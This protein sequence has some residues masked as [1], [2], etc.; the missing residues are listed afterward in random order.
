MTFIYEHTRKGSP[1][2]IPG[3][4]K[5]GKHLRFR[6]EDIERWI[7]DHEKAANGYVDGNGKA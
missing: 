7:Q 4:Y 2:P 5:F 3:A 1:D 6:L